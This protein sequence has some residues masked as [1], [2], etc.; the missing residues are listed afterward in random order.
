LLI[1]HK[2]LSHGKIARS[3]VA[4][5]LTM[6]LGGRLMDGGQWGR[7]PIPSTCGKRSV[8]HCRHEL[9]R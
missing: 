6:P 3:S 7:G 2:T 8:Q 1:K 9:G 5:P 4:K